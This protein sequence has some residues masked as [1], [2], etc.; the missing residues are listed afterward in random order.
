MWQNVLLFSGA[1]SLSLAA[2]VPWNH[3]WNTT[4]DMTFADFRSPAEMTDAQVQ[5]ASDKY[6]IISLEKCSGINSNM[7]TEDFVY[8]TAQRLKAIDPETKIFFYWDTSQAGLACYN[9]NDEFVAHPEWWLKGDDGVPIT[10]HVIDVMNTEA[11]SWWKSVPL[12]GQNGTGLYNGTPVKE[13]IDGVLADGSSWNNIAN[14]SI[15]RLEALSDAKEDMLLA[16]QTDLTAANGGKVMANGINMYGGPNE[17]PR[18]PSNH[19]VKV[20]RVA[21]AVMNEHTAAFESVNPQNASFNVDTVTQD[22]AAIDAAAAYDNGTRM[23][24]IQ[25]WPGLYAGVQQYPPVSAGGEPTPT[26]NSQWR[27][28]LTDHFPLA[29]ALFLTVAQPNTYWFYG[30]TWYDSNTGVIACPDDPTSCPSP[31]DWYVY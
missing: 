18:T 30:G 2:P 13:L 17:D 27:Q 9:A 22:F 25:T 11:V 23:V 21:E 7:K 10:P 28:A 8:S 19:N 3:G 29:H 6:R 24:F 20:L 5:F 15:A 4:A 12:G 1:A 14:I 26:N 16:L 31:L